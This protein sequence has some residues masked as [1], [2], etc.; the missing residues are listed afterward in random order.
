MSGPLSQEVPVTDT[1][2]VAPWGSPPTPLLPRWYRDNVPNVRLSAKIR[3]ENPAVITIGDL[4]SFWDGTSSPIGSPARRSLLYIADTYPPPAS[5]VVIPAHVDRAE[6]LDRP[7]RTLTANTLLRNEF[8]TGSDSLSVGH[9]LAIPNFGMASLLDLMCVVEAAPPVYLETPVS[10]TASEPL[11]GG[12]YT[13]LTNQ[14]LP[15]GSG[16]SRNLVVPYF[17][18]MVVSMKLTV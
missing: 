3:I 18:A 12:L 15:E 7:L 6:L 5:L 1:P 16:H 11:E 4:E 2:R 8:L 10:T 13:L 9:L 17:S 14:P